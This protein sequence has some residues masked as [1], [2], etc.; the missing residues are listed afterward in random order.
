MA[1]EINYESTVISPCKRLVEKMLNFTQYLNIDRNKHNT[2]AEYKIPHA[3]TLKLLSSP[4]TK[5][6]LSGLVSLADKNMLSEAEIGKIWTW[7]QW[8]HSSDGKKAFEPGGKWYE[9][10]QELISLLGNVQNKDGIPISELL[11]EET[12]C[13]KISESKNVK[14][15]TRNQI[16]T[17]FLARPRN[18]PDSD[19]NT[20]SKQVSK[21]QR[22][23]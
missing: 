18:I 2:H 15:K 8:I 5:D 3:K 7:C 23:H 13:K 1:H 9:M 19:K 4:E 21:G 14:A 22:G 12:I 10:L 17:D 11:R 6:F 20:S 16:I